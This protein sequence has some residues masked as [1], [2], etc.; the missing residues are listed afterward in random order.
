[1][2]LLQQIKDASL[3]A[4][5]AKLSLAPFLVTLYSEAAMVGKTKRNGESTDEE[6]I[7]V[8]KKFKAGAETM[9]EYSSSQDVKDQSQLEIEAIELFLPKMLSEDELTGVINGYIVSTPGVSKA[10]MGLLMSK[11]KNDYPELYDGSSASKLVK[12]ALNALG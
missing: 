11:L 8:L 12:E 5:K 9:I 1:M 4:R 6:V 7:G 3:D 2:S 10:S